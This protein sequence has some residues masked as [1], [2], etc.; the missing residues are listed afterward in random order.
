M[1]ARDRLAQAAASMS[2]ERRQDLEAERARLVHLLL[3]PAATAAAAAEVASMVAAAQEAAASAAAAATAAA[4]T[5]A[6][7]LAAQ[8]SATTVAATERGSVAGGKG[9]AKQ[10]AVRRLPPPPQLPELASAHYLLDFGFAAKGVNKTR[11]VKI[12]NTSMQSVQFAFD[13]PLLEAFGFGV[14]EAAVKLAGAPACEVSESA[15][16]PLLAWRRTLVARLQVL[17]S[18]SLHASTATS[19]STCW[20]EPT[21]LPVP[22]SPHPPPKPQTQS[23]EFTFTLLCA[24]SAVQLGP[25]EL[26]LPLPLRGGCASSPALLLTLRSHVVVPDVSASATALDFGTVWNTHCKV[27]SLCGVQ[28]CAPL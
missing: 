15:H 18:L 4:A 5:V 2:P 13:K 9:G 20:S 28:C 8:P 24:K 23:V 1:A 7:P 3:D 14:S 27:R 21:A 17:R 22:R 25:V 11:K 26:T 16:H 12:T 6:A 19:T 10:T